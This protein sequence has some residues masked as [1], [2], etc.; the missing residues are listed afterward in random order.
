[1]K[2][3]SA[4]LGALLFISISF[5]ACEKT[6]TGATGPQGATGTANVQYATWNALDMNFSSSDSAYTQTIT[7]DSIT[8]SILDSGVVLTY[9]KYTDP[10]TNQTTVLNTAGY[11]D[12]FFTAGTI[13]LYSYY[14]Y[15]GL[16][17]RY[18]IIPGGVPTGRLA[19]SSASAYSK[20]A[21][22]KMSYEEVMK[23]LGQQE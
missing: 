17:F 10:S 23:L 5:T 14:D 4:M 2:P 15:T 21:L 12:V 8:Q 1:M 3:I 6:E 7:A 13:N 20:E 22:Q 9:M 16:Y 18:V 11:M 19:A